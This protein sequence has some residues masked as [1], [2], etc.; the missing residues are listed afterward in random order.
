MCAHMTSISFT[1]LGSMHNTV[2][3]PALK[4]EGQVHPEAYFDQRLHAYYLPAWYLADETL[5][6][7]G[8]Y[9]TIAA[10]QS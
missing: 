3:N 7:A 6:R 8:R 2:P 10:H 1:S 5:E 4:V 9:Q